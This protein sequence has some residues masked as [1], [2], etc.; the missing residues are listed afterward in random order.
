MSF[1]SESVEDW[2]RSEEL[3]RALHMQL[4]YDVSARLAEEITSGQRKRG[5]GNKSAVHLDTSPLPHIE[6]SNVEK[7]DEWKRL[8]ADGLVGQVLREFGTLAESYGGLAAAVSKPP[9]EDLVG[10]FERYRALMISAYAPVRALWM[11]DKPE[12]ERNGLLEPFISPVPASRA[13]ETIVATISSALFPRIAPL[14][15]RIVFDFVDPNH[16]EGWKAW[17][18]TLID[19][20]QDMPK[21]MVEAT[22]RYNAYLW[23]I[24]Q[25]ALIVLAD[26]VR[27]RPARK[28]LADDVGFLDAVVV[29]SYCG[30]LVFDYAWLRGRMS[31]VTREEQLAMRMEMI[32]SHCAAERAILE[33]PKTW[34]EHAKGLNSA[35]AAFASTLVGCSRSRVPVKNFGIPLSYL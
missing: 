24:S 8:D 22:K 32:N 4:S 2:E 33:Y 27:A 10:T 31:K 16:R 29:A 1:E 18:P 28:R 34:G 14:L 3:Y 15:R 12:S 5:K 7:E 21:G 30:P 11:T 25:V 13:S 17:D 6:F 20:G 23:P 26:L 35:T 9:A 19:I